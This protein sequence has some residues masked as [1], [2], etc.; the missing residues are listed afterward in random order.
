MEKSLNVNRNKILIRCLL[1]MLFAGILNSVSVFVKP[2]ATYY[3]GLPMQSQM[4]ALRC[5]SSGRPAPFWAAGSCPKSARRKLSVWGSVLFGAGLVLSGMIPKSSPWMLY[6]TFSFMQGLGNGMAYTAA[7]YVATGWYPDKR[8]LATGL[9]MAF[10]GGSSA[11]LA[12][13]CS[14]LT[15]ATNIKV[16]LIVVGLVAG[17]VCLFSALGISQ[18]PL[19]YVPAGYKPKEKKEGDDTQLASYP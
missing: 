6:I 17:L 15:L 4:S 11:F 16:T 2:L 13:L 19:G 5:C 10:N 7:T 1:I 18:A 12:P 14:K 9:C 8:G 3:N